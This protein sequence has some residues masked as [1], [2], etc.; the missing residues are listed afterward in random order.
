MK[1]SFVICLFMFPFLFGYS[2]N[3]TI[4]LM[5]NG[6]DSITHNSLLLKSVFIQNTTAGCDTTIYGAN[7]SI[8]LTVP[9]GIPE[10]TLFGSEPF[11]VMP[12]V[13]NPFYGTT[14]VDIQQKQ[15]GKLQLTAIDANGKVKSTYKGEFNSGFHKFEIES[16]SS[17]LLILVVSHGN[18][19]RSVKLINYGTSSGENRITLIETDRQNL[20][21]N[22]SK[23]GFTYRFGDQLLF[24]SSCN[25][26]MDKIISD[27]PTKDSSYTFELTPTGLPTV[28]TV[29]T[30]YVS[31]ITMTTAIS[32]I[33]VTSDGG[34]SVIAR[35]TCWSLLPN[36][37]TADSHTTNGEG[38]G[39]FIS[40]LSGLTASTTY[41]ARG[42]ATNSIGTAYGNQIEFQ[43]LGTPTVTTA[44][45]TNI[46]AT[47]VISGGNVLS[48]GGAAVIARGVCWGTSS[49]PTISDSHTFD[50]NET[51]IFISEVIGLT[52]NSSYYIRAYATN[53]E[54]T[55]YGNEITFTT[56]SPFIC[57]ETVVY[58]GMYSIAP[59]II[60]ALVIL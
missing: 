26:Y 22:Y 52:P 35:G 10:P 46:G 36:P 18:I 31:F 49:N 3:Q 59:L 6:K 60:F 57:G 14:R 40:N 19:S 47:Y 7:P 27:S 37:T 38:T 42:Y 16:S 53:S 54:G 50:G 48:D 56:L 30:T 45:V 8:V 9:L 58:G 12:P 33:N 15:E 21:S 25:G 24:K 20:K 32:S 13:P 28:P 39:Y 44:Q 2:Q 23:S 34:A 55:G 4:T 17:S 1:R 29:I 43:T 51:G 5:F 41:Y 11:I